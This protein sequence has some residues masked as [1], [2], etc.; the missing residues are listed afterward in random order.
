[1]VFCFVPFAVS[2]GVM[3]CSVFLVELFGFH[4]GKDDEAG[5]RG[6]DIDDD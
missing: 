3:L 5:E 2:F 1:M 4:K 6:D